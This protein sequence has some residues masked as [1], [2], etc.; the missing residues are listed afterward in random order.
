MKKKRVYVESTVISYLTAK[1]SRD[2]V[3]QAQQLLT[4]EWWERRN[5]WDLFISPVVIREIRQGDPEAARERVASV[6]GLAVLPDTDEVE[7][8]AM[9]S[10]IEP[11][12]KKARMLRSHHDLLL[13]W[14][15]AGKKYNN[16]ITEGLN[17]KSRTRIK[18]AYG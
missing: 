6:V 9:K 17:N 12:K 7:R 15:K 11:M 18:M 16:G 5:R 2:I 3:K 14:F 4:R 8:M 13:N 1:S 10:R